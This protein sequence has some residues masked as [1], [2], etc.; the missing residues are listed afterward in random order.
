MV[1]SHDFITFKDKVGIK[2]LGNDVKKRNMKFHIVK[3]DEIRRK[4]VSSLKTY[5]LQDQLVRDKCEGES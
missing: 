5:R 2:E 4:R 3:T 1:S